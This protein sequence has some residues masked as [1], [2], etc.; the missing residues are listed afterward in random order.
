MAA[1]A[2]VVDK[3]LLAI[4][5]GDSHAA[6]SGDE[7]VDGVVRT[8]ES[9]DDIGEDALALPVPLDDIPKGPSEESALQRCNELDLA[10]A[11]AGQESVSDSDSDEPMEAPPR[12]QQRPTPR[13]DIRA[14]DVALAR[15]SGI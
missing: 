7:A 13:R 15:S 4:A 1:T 6:A 8:V 2:E 14:V 5:N 11:P 12:R 3:S 10:A 9:S